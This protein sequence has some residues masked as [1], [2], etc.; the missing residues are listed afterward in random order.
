M[1]VCESE[2]VAVNLND[3]DIYLTEVDWYAWIPR[4]PGMPN[5]RL[6]LRRRISTGQ[7]EV[8]RAFVDTTALAMP[9]LV[10]VT[11]TPNGIHQ[12]IFTGDL[13]GALAAGNA[14]ARKYHGE[15]VGNDKP[16]EHRYPNRS[17]LCTVKVKN[18]SAIS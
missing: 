8:Y 12:V 16:C 5:H 10:A 14:E 7:F 4:T 6:S 11:N 15:E 18:E 9:G 2:F 17:S 1:F 13:A 3:P